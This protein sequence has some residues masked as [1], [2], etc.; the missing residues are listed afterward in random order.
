MAGAAWVGMETVHCRGGREAFSG[1]WAE[2]S[3]RT[4]SNGDTLSCATPR[5]ITS[6]CLCVCICVNAGVILVSPFMCFWK[7]F[8]FSHFPENGFCQQD[9]H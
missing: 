9:L 8:G 1:P 7:F 4:S 5:D 3:R 6:V 2:K